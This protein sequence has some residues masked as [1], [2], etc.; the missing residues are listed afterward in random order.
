[1]VPNEDAGL[2]IRA[3]AVILRA[4][5]FRPQQRTQS[6]SFRGS[7]EICKDVFEVCGERFL[8]W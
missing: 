4:T 3:L 8:G 6:T 2:R 1:M 5:L 7:L